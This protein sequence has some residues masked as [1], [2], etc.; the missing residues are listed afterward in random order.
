MHDTSFDVDY[1]FSIHA[2]KNT[3]WKRLS[4]ES[5]LSRD[6]SFIIRHLFLHVISQ[7]GHLKMDVSFAINLENEAKESMS[8]A[9]I[10][11]TLL[12]Q[13]SGSNN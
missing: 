3:D 11:M 13:V 2:F 9:C 5:I 4:K 6:M 8:L 12:K 1:S 10:V 7:I